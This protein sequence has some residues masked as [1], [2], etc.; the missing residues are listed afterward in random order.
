M[1][2]EVPKNELSMHTLTPHGPNKMWYQMKSM[3]IQQ[4]VGPNQIKTLNP[5]P[6]THQTS[7]VS[8]LLPLPF[9]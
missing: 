5:K 7:G 3:Y 2:F 1:F 6:K 4:N 8:H 9:T